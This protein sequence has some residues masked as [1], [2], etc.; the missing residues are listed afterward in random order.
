MHG[1]TMHMQHMRQAL[2]GVPGSHPPTQGN[3]LSTTLLQQSYILEPTSQNIATA[4]L[5]CTKTQS[6]CLWQEPLL[7]PCP[8]ASL[9]TVQGT[10]RTP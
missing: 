7:P 1:P 6:C 3:K 5:H 4:V 9:L 2:P 10:K 8:Y